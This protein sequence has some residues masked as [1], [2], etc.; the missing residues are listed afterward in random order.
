MRKILDKYYGLSWVGLLRFA[1]RST[2]FVRTAILARILVPAQF[3]IFAIASL[4]LAFLETITETGIN[5]FLVQLRSSG[6][7]DKYVNTAWVVSIVRGVIV[8]ISIIIFSPG[9]ST[10]FRSPESLGIL[11]LTSIVPLIRGFIN[12]SVA[13]F[14]KEIRFD[15]EFIYKFPVYLIDSAVAIILAL[16]IKS[17]VALI[18]GLIS[19]ALLEIIISFKKAKPVPSFEFNFKKTKKVIARGKWMT[20]S[21]IFDYFFQNVD[22]FVVGKMLNQYS[23]GI[24]QV[25]YKIS[26]LPITEVSQVFSRVA[27]P[28]Y[29]KNFDNKKKLLLVFTKINFTTISLVLPLGLIIFL[30]PDLIIKIVLGNNWLEATKVLKLLAVYGTLRGIFFPM[31]AIFLS[32]N[33]QEYVTIT[34]LVGA[35]GLII[36]IIPFVTSFGIIGAGYSAILGTV[37]MIP[38]ILYFVIK[39][40]K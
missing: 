26:S 29:K 8:S 18:Y 21:G 36:S 32:A 10:F 9:I 39:I 14:Q 25:A 33:K 7:V 37:L 12:P 31:M 30:F 4:V 11:Y 5:I 38:V 35:V 19:G 3:G 40:F 2:S 15:K 6:E 16:L 27:F 1:I 13:K 23:L 22:D 24:Y 34:T 17:P 28:V 20:M